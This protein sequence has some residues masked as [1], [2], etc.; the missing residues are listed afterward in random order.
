M[1]KADD[2]RR[3]FVIARIGTNTLFHDDT[4]HIAPMAS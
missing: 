2:Y 1:G 4:G 3:V